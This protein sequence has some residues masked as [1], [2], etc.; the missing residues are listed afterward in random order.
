MSPARRFVV[1]VGLGVAAIVAGALVAIR[2]FRQLD[3]ELLAGVAI[4]GGVA[5]IVVAVTNGH[6][7]PPR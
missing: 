7:R 5:M 2:N 6:D 4:F 3:M 1:L